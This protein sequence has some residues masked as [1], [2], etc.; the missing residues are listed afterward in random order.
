MVWIPA[1]EAESFMPPAATKLAESVDSIYSF[2]LIASLVSFLILMGGLA[3]FVSKYRRK[4]ASDQTSYIPHNHVLEFIWSFIPFVIFMICFGWGAKVYMD[5]RKVPSGAMEIHVV[6][7]KWDWEFIYKNGRKITS[8]VDDK[9]K[10]IPATMT[11]PLNKPVRLIMTSSKVN[12]NDKKD[13]AV[14]HS[15]FVPAFRVKQDIVP[16]RYTQLSFTPTKKGRFYVFCTEYCGTGHSTM[17]GRVEVVDEVAFN[18]W[19]LGDESFDSKEMSLADKGKEIYKGK[20]ACIG[21]HSLDGSEMTGPTWKDLY[22]SPRNFSDGTS[23]RAD[24]N[25]IKESILNS[26]AKTVKGYPP[27]Q[28]PSY[29]G[30][31]T[32]DD[33][34]AVIEFIK[35]LK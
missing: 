27:N 21:C 8:D 24:D 5:M 25:Y 4:S 23:A 10:R 26:N 1:A 20:G 13:R 19:I 33:V 11:V 30:Q 17:L 18:D 2:L 28:M 6:A 9:G 22:G 3:Y 14:L 16:G 31:L 34:T 15:F 32:D 35:T 7:K 29:Q 12:P